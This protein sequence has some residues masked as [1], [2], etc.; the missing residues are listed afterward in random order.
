MKNSQQ[1]PFQKRNSCGRIKFIC[2]SL[3]LLGFLKASKE[4]FAAKIVGEKNCSVKIDAEFSQG[5]KLFV[6]GPP[7]EGGKKIAMIEVMRSKGG[8]S[9]GKVVKG[10]KHCGK[11]KGFEVVEGSKSSSGLKSTSESSG[12]ASG[13]KSDKKS[14]H[15]AGNL[16]G[17]TVAAD[18]MGTL[19]FSLWSSKGLYQNT[20]ENLPTLNLLGFGL[21]LDLWPGVFVNK[22]SLLMQMFGIGLSYT[23]RFSY[24]EIEVAP[25]TESKDQT[26]G[27]IS[28]SATTLLAEFMVRYP[29][30]N[31]MLSTE[32]RVGYISHALKVKLSSP[33]ALSR[34][35]LRDFNLSGYGFGLIQRVYLMEL[36]RLNVGFVFP[37]TLSGVAD[38]TSEK[39]KDKTAAYTE[40]VTKPAGLMFHASVDGYFGLLRGTFGVKYESFSM[41]VPIL[42]GGE[43]S[44]SQSFIS[45]YLGLGILF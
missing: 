27:K 24:P 33:G 19:P 25:P 6:I 42:E 29:Y 39:T 13:K 43:L 2:F 32:A 8:V 35:P 26:F 22:H 16:K 9:L 14:A 45:P 36:L 21:D 44:V 3:C 41:T 28:P 5:D 12:E 11:M 7:S 1:G 17:K 31:G 37:L 20:Q 4:A 23:S 18:V 30:L 38:N 10:N 40:V 15:S 34:S